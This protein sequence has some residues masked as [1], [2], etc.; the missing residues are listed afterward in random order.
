MSEQQVDPDMF[1][2]MGLFTKR[3]YRDTYS[4]IDTRST[5]KD[6][7]EGKV[8]IVSGASR[9]IGPAF[10]QSFAQAGAKGLALIASSE[11]NLE[12]TIA[13]VKKTNPKVEVL[14]LGFDMTDEK[15]VLG[16]FEKIKEKFG[17]ADVL[18][19][20]AGAFANHDAVHDFEAKTW[21]R[22]VVS[23]LPPS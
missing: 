14:P 1:Q 7:Q 13:L 19:N 23:F 15:S 20:N 8:I 2:K 4:A 6:S 10:A 22:D 17:S 5:L 18:I 3:Y 16:A 11:K 21:W 9:G 12:A